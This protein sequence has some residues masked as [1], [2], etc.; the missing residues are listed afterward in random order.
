[1]VVWRET[2]TAHCCVATGDRHEYDRNLQRF[3]QMLEQAKPIQQARKHARL[4]FQY[5]APKLA[6]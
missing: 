5:D 1:M 6:I 3:H 4:L 2:F